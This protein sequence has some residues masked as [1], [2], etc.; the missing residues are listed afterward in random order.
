[1][2]HV[3]NFIR[4]LF[5]KTDAEIQQRKNDLSQFLSPAVSPCNLGAL[6]NFYLLL[7]RYYYSHY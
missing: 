7:F 5:C 3:L 4:F 2:E 1:M 6:A